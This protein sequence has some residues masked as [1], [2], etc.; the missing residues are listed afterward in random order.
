M[1]NG[2]RYEYRKSSEFQVGLLLAIDRRALN[3][4]KDYTISRERVGVGGCRLVE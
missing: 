3:A 2:D 4:I 1:I